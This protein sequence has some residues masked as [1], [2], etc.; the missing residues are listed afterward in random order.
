MKKSILTA[1]TIAALAGATLVGAPANAVTA[2]PAHGIFAGGCRNWSVTYGPGETPA[3]VS[4]AIFTQGRAGASGTVVV[5]DMA[6]GELGTFTDSAA[7]D[8]HVRDVV[9]FQDGVASG[10]HSYWCG[11]AH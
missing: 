11:R 8:G 1:T 3:R 9:V 10:F 5:A 6:A 2:D 7:R 4:V